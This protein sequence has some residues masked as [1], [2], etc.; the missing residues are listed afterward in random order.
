MHDCPPLCMIL[1]ALQ[2]FPLAHVKSVA[3]LLCLFEKISQNAA[4]S[5]ST[6]L[7]CRNRSGNVRLVK[8]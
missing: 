1:T 5:H 8:I 4:Q 6:Q 2:T 7:W 3:D